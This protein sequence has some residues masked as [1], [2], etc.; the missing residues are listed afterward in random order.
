MGAILNGVGALLATPDVW[1]CDFAG[2]GFASKA[3]TT[4]GLWSMPISLFLRVFRQDAGPLE[5]GFAIQL[6]GGLA[7]DLGFALPF[8]SWEF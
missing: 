5:D 7:A 6:F 3:P 4:E 1:N 8:F 2:A